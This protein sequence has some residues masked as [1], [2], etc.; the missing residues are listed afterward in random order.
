[1]YFVLKK[2]FKGLNINS[3]IQHTY[4]IH[5]HTMAYCKV[6]KCRYAATHTTVAHKCGKC[7]G[8]GHGQIECGDLA[9]LKHLSFYFSETVALGDRCAVA[10][11]PNSAT[12]TS[13]GHVCAFCDCRED[14]HLK[15]CP[16]NIRNGGTA[17]SVTDDPLSIGFDPRPNA[18]SQNVLPGQYITFYGGM[19]CAWYARKNR[20]T[21]DL[22]YFFLH[23]DARGQ[24]GDDSSDIPRL[25][26]F[27]NAYK[28]QVVRDDFRVDA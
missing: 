28:L 8:Y 24:Y 13:E 2:W 25:R 20:V 18:E 7:G 26:A 17:V 4:I 6:D 21:E 19:G 23:S 5:H 16:N 12:H 27:T 10:W 9:A 1:M 14:A 15:N 22:E 11:C 3:Y